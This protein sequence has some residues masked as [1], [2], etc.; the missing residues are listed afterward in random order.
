MAEDAALVRAALQQRESAIRLLVARLRCVPRILRALNARRGCPLGEHD[1]ADLAQDTLAVILRKLEG[2]HQNCSLEAWVYRICTY[3]LMNAIRRVGRAP[4]AIARED[5]V[6]ELPARDE[7]SEEDDQGELHW[8]MERLEAREAAIIRRKC[9]EG[10]TFETVARE[11]A[12]S[13]GT[14]KT[15]YYRGLRK[16]REILADRYMEDPRW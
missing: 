6:E 12:L 14:V 3:E 2:F 16:L 5:G 8:A 7:N 11:L 13:L 1:L 15:R 4:L 10:E 9:L